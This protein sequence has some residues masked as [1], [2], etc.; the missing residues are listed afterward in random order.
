VPAGLSRDVGLA[1]L[2]DVLDMGEQPTTVGRFEIR[3]QLGR[4]GMGTVFRAYDPELERDVALKV[5]DGTVDDVGA[6]AV[7]KEARAL[8]RLAHPHVVGVYELGVEQDQVFL[9][10]EFVPGRTVRQRVAGGPPPDTRELI[11]WF[12]Q[13]GRGL[14]AAH[15]AGLIHRDIKPDNLLVADDGRV[16][17]ADFGLA[18]MADHTEAGE[19]AGTPTYMAPEVLSEGLASPASDQYAYCASLWR[20][21]D[22][23]SL[24]RSPDAD[25]PLGIRQVLARG[26]APEPSQRWPSMQALL[27]ALVPSPEVGPTGRQRALLLQRVERIWIDGVLEASLVDTPH[28][29]LPMSPAES[30]VDSPWEAV[31]SEQDARTSGL[32]DLLEV[33]Q[34]SLLLLGEPGGGKTITLL[35]LAR[36]LL[37]E[38]R[39]DP[40]APAPVVLLLASLGDHDGAVDDWIEQQLVS[41]YGLPRGAVRERLD[42]GALVLL[43]DG[44]DEIAPSQQARCVEALSV[45][46]SE[47]GLP[48]A[49]TCRTSD[50]ER[51]PVRLRFG[52]A[53]VIDPLPPAVVAAH[54]GG[55]EGSTALVESLRTPLMVSLLARA[56]VDLPVGAAQLPWLYERYIAHQLN[57]AAIPRNEREPFLAALRELAMAMNRGERSELWLEQ[58]APGWVFDDGRRHVATGLAVAMLTACCVLANVVVGAV[59]EGDPFSGLLFGL[60]S[61]PMILALNGGVGL[62]PVERL[63]F[64]V[65]RLA[66]LL[67]LALA[68]GIVFGAIYG[69]FY[70]VWVNVVFGAVAGLVTT[71]TLAFEP[72]LQESRIRPN[73]GMRQAL[74]NGLGIGTLGFVLGA[75]V[76]GYVAVPWVLP[77]LEPPSTLVGLPHPERSAAAVAG[78]LLGMI[79]GMVRGG[80]SVLLHVAV[81]LVLNATT[82][83]PLRLVSLLDRAADLGL[84]RRVGGGYL[85]LHRTFQDFLAERP[86]GMQAE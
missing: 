10:M 40:R 75:V 44:L 8:A 49:V 59:V 71:F 2:F 38:A 80:W 61:V 16:R 26:L 31:A 50:Y 72:S 42:A 53:V 70:I 73:Q 58:L 30:S 86:D 82:S 65:G 13:A 64:S 39:L 5:L 76:L 15:E 54:L 74:V 37:D 63:R 83:V 85:F 69:L 78:P 1:I 34:G 62:Q 60:V 77:Y 46:R 28:L 55:R 79:A 43:L 36:A 12:V 6:E 45:F 51:L 41:K 25:I 11:D 47:R 20:L 66:R 68:L 81:R 19:V 67:P 57:A 32:A 21:L 48:M 9:A 7:R 23:H 29:D 35:R 84:M 52:H 18:C 3:E 33:G 22:P 56:G 14:Q 17:V 4:G 24:L 27:D